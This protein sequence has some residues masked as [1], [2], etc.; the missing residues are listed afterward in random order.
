MRTFTALIA[1]LVLCSCQTVPRETQRPYTLIDLTEAFAELHDSTIDLPAEQRVARFE[2]EIVP[3]FP[4]FYARSR[5]SQMSD[6]DYA[7]RI[8]RALDEFDDYRDEYLETAESFEQLLAPA[9]GAFAAAFPDIGEVGDIYLLHSLGE[10]DGGTRTFDDELYIIFGADV[11]TWAH[12]YDDEQPFFHH[13]LFHV[14]HRRSFPECETIWCGLWTEGLA[15]Y[16]AHELNPGASDSQLLLTVPEPIRQAL[17]DNLAEAACAVRARLDSHDENDISAL[18]SFERLNE[19]LP[20]RFGY[21]VGFLVAQEAGRTAS[22]Q[23]LADLDHAE[24]RAA[25]DAALSAMADCAPD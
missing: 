14:L 18:F 7:G 5:Y 13:E 17:D 24:A 10:M 21:Y 6:E 12:P 19:R 23:E 2:A 11:M 25:V 20:P 4:E 3:L 1:T 9:Y 22:L 8:I 15:V 16:V